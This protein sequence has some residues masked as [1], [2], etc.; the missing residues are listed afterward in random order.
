ME[1]FQSDFDDMKKRHD[2]C[3][4]PFIIITIKKSSDWFPTAGDTSVLSLII[5]LW[6]PGP[7]WSAPESENIFSWNVYHA[8][9]IKNK[10]IL[11]TKLEQG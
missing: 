6:T 5:S 10:D 11:A 2:F 3:L 1:Y 7:P 8:R 4:L 9:D